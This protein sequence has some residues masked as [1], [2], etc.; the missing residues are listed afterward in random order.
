[1]LVKS[2]IDEDFV[3]YKKPCMFISTCYCDWKCC[4]DCEEKCHCQNSNLASMKN[5]KVDIGNLIN[6]YLA[7]SI[8]ESVVIAGLEPMIQIE[9]VLE[10]IRQFRE[11]SEDDIVIYTGYYENEVKE[12]IEMLSK[13]KN[14]IVKFGRYVPGQE[15]HFDDILGVMLTNKEQY[16]K[17][18]S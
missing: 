16:A 13:Y 9:E 10:F 8:T 11:K 18:I 12:E 7:N 15:S 4:I 2:I 1:M 17:V 3:N 14:I 6:R 5:I